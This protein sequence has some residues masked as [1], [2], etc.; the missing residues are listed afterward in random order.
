MPR[1]CEI[2]RDRR[3]GFPC[4]R[5][6]ET[7]RFVS[8][9][10]VTKLQVEQWIAEGS[11]D[12]LEDPSR[13]TDLINR[14]E[15]R[16]VPSEYPDTVRAAGRLPVPRCCEDTITSLLATNLTLWTAADPITSKAAN[17]PVRFPT[18]TSEWGLFVKWSGG[19]APGYREWRDALEA[20]A[21]VSTGDLVRRALDSL[22]NWAPPVNPLVECVLSTFAGACDVGAGGLPFMNKGVLELITDRQDF[23]RL[24]DPEHRFVYR[25]LVVGETALWPMLRVTGEHAWQPVL[26]P[27]LPAVGLRLWYDEDQVEFDSKTGRPTVIGLA[28]RP[29]PSPRLQ[30]DGGKSTSRDGR[31]ILGSG[32]GRVTMRRICPVRYCEISE[33]QWRDS[34]PI[35]HWREAGQALRPESSEAPGSGLMGPQPGLQSGANSTF[36]YAHGHERPNRPGVD[37]Q[38]AIHS[39]Y[40]GIARGDASKVRS[41]SLS[42]FSKSGKSVWMLTCTGMMVF[43]QGKPWLAE[44]FPGDWRFNAVNCYMDSFAGRPGDDSLHWNVYHQIEDMWIGGDVPERNPAQRRALRYPLLFTR[45]RQSGILQLQRGK[46]D[47][48]IVLNDMSGEDVVNPNSIA[49]HARK[50]ELLTHLGASTDVVFLAPAHELR[51]AGAILEQ[52][53]GGLELVTWNGSALKCGEINLILVISQIDRLRHSGQES[54]ELLDIFLRQPHVWPRERNRDDLGRYVA[55]MRQ[56]HYDTEE[57]LSSRVPAWV[58][59]ARKFRSVRYCGLSALGF[60]PVMRSRVEGKDA[61]LPFEPQP[62][63]AVDPLLWLL[64]D[65]GWL[66]P[67]TDLGIKDWR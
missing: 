12:H 47:L 7:R 31:T 13:V 54:E 20:F 19:T 43:P 56:V 3:T 50:Q 39:R 63:R 58:S 26:H 51:T 55:A 28:S 35:F 65:N 52:F 42:G 53:I 38:E 21:D 62:V 18:P 15:L 2:A 37:E 30:V 48:A 34:R 41:V 24:S 40:L 32:G 59:A 45:E 8:L 60:A 64:I 49:D 4:V 22:S 67:K 17:R 9:L 5:A 16:E 33:N 66:S 29:T 23:D 6:P 36:S 44:A 27:H 25:P 61:Y 10:P 11:L 1:E 14:M 57:W 46:S